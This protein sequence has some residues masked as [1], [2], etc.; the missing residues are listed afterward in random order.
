MHIYLLQKPSN[1]H[2]VVVDAS[3]A[4]PQKSVAAPAK[5]PAAKTETKKEKAKK[6][7]KAATTKAQA[8]P[9]VEE[10]EQGDIYI[11]IYLF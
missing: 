7:N 4:A 8:P 6:A 2:V 11:L 1:G 9:A 3:P 10:T 5:A